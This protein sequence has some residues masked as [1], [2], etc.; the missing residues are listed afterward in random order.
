MLEKKKKKLKKMQR[1]NCLEI[2]VNICLKNL[3]VINLIVYML[4][5][6]SKSTRL[7]THKKTLLVKHL[8]IVLH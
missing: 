6:L 1:Q 7:V 5:L 3:S 8:N 4:I 2:A